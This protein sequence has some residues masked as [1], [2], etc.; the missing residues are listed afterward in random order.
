MSFLGFM[1]AMAR[2]TLNSSGYL[3]QNGHLI[4]EL[5]FR[6]AQSGFVGITGTVWT[7]LPDGAIEGSRFIND[8]VL[9]PYK[10]CQLKRHDLATIANSLS[11]GNFIEL[12]SE[13]ASQPTVNPHHITIRLGEKSSTL[14][15]Q[16]DETIKNALQAR[17]NQGET[18]QAGFLNIAL[19]INQLIQHRCSDN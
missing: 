1:S 11:Q 18:L 10:L 6:N 13:I 3:K 14:K 5:E 9:S 4:G 19:K 8:T 15:L 12:P 16:P 7:I 2:S 17:R